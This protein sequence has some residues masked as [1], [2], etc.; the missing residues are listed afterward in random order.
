MTRRVRRRKKKSYFE[1]TMD[2]VKAILLVVIA[3]A[4][5]VFVVFF[6][7]DSMQDEDDRKMKASI[8]S[9]LF[10]KEEEETGTGA[11]ETEETET[12]TEEETKEFTLKDGL[13]VD[14]DGNIVYVKDGALLVSTFLEE[15]GKLYYFDEIGMACTDRMNLDAMILHFG[16]DGALKN[17]TVDPGYQE[18]YTDY[19]AEY[20]GLTKDNLLM[21]YL[22]EDRKFGRFS[23]IIYKKSADTMSHILGGN[24][25][26]QY[27]MP[28]TMQIADG[29]VYWL[30]FVNDPDELES[31]LCGKLFRMKP[32]DGKREIYSEDVTGFI[33]FTDPEGKTSLWYSKDGQVLKADLS[34]F[35]E[36]NTPVTF[37]E[38]MDYMT[39][40][41][42]GKLY[43]KTASG[44]PVAK[45]SDAF[46]VLGF[47]YRLGPDGEI[48]GSGE[49]KS[50]KVGNYTY[51]VKTGEM[52]GMERSVIVRTDEAG[53]EEMI[54]G[55]FAGSAKNIYHNPNDNYL[56]MEYKYPDGSCYIACSSLDG[57]VDML[58]GG[59]RGASSMKILG[60]ADGRVYVKETYP[61]GGSFTEALDVYALSGL[62]LGRTPEATVSEG[63]TEQAELT[64]PSSI[65]PS[66]QGPGA[67]TAETGS[68]PGVAEDPVALTGP[69]AAPFGPGVTP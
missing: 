9:T 4:A 24:G 8:F 44:Y 66:S 23:E 6:I 15:H 3:A 21:A 58:T 13:T 62:A 52:F 45:E 48:L 50:V 16:K 38:D 47:S 49:Q 43:L 63:T 20:P 12:G 69:G 39:E 18:P 65:G 60:F 56:Y 41:S 14:Q 42:D 40:L 10:K 26:P 7:R 64:G 67:A 32:G 11:G 34:E 35:T 17:I 68:A 29:N 22:K 31:L 61:D 55:E 59:D 28:G 27:T 19:L 30:P 25:S 1:E 54:S 5:V 53:I 33:V 46:H 57:Y 37:T 36:D 51:S 2:I